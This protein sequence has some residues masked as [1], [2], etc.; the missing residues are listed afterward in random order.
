MRQTIAGDLFTFLIVMVSIF[1]GFGMASAALFL[2]TDD[3]T[4]TNGGDG[5]GENGSKRPLERMIEQVFQHYVWTLVPA[6]IH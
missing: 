5:Q 6:A 3:A 1:F 4:D 2:E